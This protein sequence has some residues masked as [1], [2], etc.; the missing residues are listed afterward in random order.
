LDAIVATTL[1]V[2]LSTLMIWAF[3]FAVGQGISP[4]RHLAGRWVLSRLL[5]GILAGPVLG[6]ICY[7][8]ALKSLEA[9]VVSTLSAMSPL[10][11]LPMVYLRYRSHIGWH[12]AGA[13]AA[14]ICGVALICLR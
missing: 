6:M 13:T 2:G 12:I 4:L 3:A 11:I 9:G 8:T 10:F 7:V 5:P 1:R 14:A